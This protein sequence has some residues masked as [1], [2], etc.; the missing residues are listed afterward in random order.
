MSKA[1]ERR[2]DML[3]RNWIARKPRP[4]FVRHLG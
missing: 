3:Y 4:R 1:L 2:I